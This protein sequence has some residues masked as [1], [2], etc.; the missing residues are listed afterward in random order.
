MFPFA[1]AQ[2][3]VAALLSMTCYEKYLMVKCTTGRAACQR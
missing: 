3:G 1:F 2:D